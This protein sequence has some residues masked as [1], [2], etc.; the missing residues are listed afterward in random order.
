MLPGLIVTALGLA[1]MLVS[2]FAIEDRDEMLIGIA[3]GGGVV[4]IGL[5]A[6][7]PGLIVFSRCARS[8]S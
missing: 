3:S 8:A 6:A 1:A 2:A 7:I 5:I 4:L